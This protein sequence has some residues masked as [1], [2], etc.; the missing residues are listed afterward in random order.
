MRSSRNLPKPHRTLPEDPVPNT[1]YSNEAFFQRVF[2][3]LRT[4]DFQIRAMAELAPGMVVVHDNY[5]GR[6]ELDVYFDRDL[7]EP[8]N[9]QIWMSDGKDTLV[10]P[11]LEGTGIACLQ[12]F[13][14]MNRPQNFKEF[15]G[16]SKGTLKPKRADV[17][18]HN[19]PR[20]MEVPAELR[21]A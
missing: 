14:Y 20:E 17:F 19:L 11:S 9:P 13:A 15:H 10:P 16:M 6:G 12:S 8:V 21:A 1:E 7:W 18:W 4:C 5:Q 2:A 3:Y